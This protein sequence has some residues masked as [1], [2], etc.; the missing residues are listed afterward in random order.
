M[1]YS[2]IASV[3]G[4]SGQ[5]NH[6]AA[7]SFM[8]LLAWRRRAAGL[9]GLSIGWGA[10][11]EI[12][13]AAD[14]GVDSRADARGIGTISPERG[15]AW[16]DTLMD[17][18]APHVAVFPVRWADF[19]AQPGMDTPFVAH[20]L[21]ATRG[22]AAAARPAAAVAPAATAVSI[23]ERLGEANAA[24]RHELL[25]GFVGEHVARVIGAAS[26]EAIDP[27]QPLNE[28]GLDSLM[29]VELRN[30]LGSGLG[31]ARSLPATLVFDHPTLEALAV[32]L[33]SDVLPAPPQAAIAAPA[34]AADA[35]GAI[36]DLSD[37]EIEKLFAKKM[38]RS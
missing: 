9:P 8:D 12:G 37:E 31:L 28:L 16:L 25:L 7:N 29:A 34:A 38:R 3:L 32:Y 35:V 2:S 5:G 18:S 22:T 27:R 14:R 26:G 11:S 33:A 19:L 15:L 21:E 30:R 17:G 24:R 20:L 36:D 4:S 1:L 23:L 6:A 13:A 10:W